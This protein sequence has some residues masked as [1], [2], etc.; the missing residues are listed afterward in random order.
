[1]KKG[2]KG[3]WKRATVNN[4]IHHPRLTFSSPKGD[5]KFAY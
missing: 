3:A 1:M 2:G 5:C 4:P